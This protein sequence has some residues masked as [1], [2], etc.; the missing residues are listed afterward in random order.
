M[1]AAD[2]RFDREMSVLAG[3]TATL[4]M[5]SGRVKKGKKIE[6]SDLYLSEEEARRKEALRRR[7]IEDTKRMLDEAKRADERTPRPM[8]RGYTSG[9]SIQEVMAERSRSR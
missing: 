7:R 5:F 2:W 9:K 6:G 4:V 1:E 3:F 8:G